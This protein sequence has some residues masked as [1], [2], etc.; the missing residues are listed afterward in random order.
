VRRENSVVLRLGLAVTEPENDEDLQEEEDPFRPPASFFAE[1][2]DN[3]VASSRIKDG[4]LY[5]RFYADAIPT[6]ADERAG[7][8]VLEQLLKNEGRHGAD[9]F[10][11]RIAPGYES[12]RAN[13]PPPEL[14]VVSAHQ[15][16]SAALTPRTKEKSTMSTEKDLTETQR[17]VL[18]AYRAGERAEGR[19]PTNV[20]LAQALPHLSGYSINAA[21]K[22]LV[23]RGLAD[24]PKKG[25]RVT[26]STERRSKPAKVNRA[27]EVAAPVPTQRGPVDPIVAAIQGEAA[28]AAA[29]LDKLNRLLQALAD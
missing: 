8:R 19:P 25:G 9:A 28:V 12:A 27:R 17:A 23:N 14:P 21:R 29:R 16:T 18:D 4:R 6:D 20:E 24:K 1:P 26:T 10:V 2:N 15:K 22:D 11:P 7:K 3:I 13:L 5:V